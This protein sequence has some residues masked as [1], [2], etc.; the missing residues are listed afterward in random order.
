MG[1]R[2]I[3]ILGFVGVVLRVGPARADQTVNLTAVSMSV[4]VPDG[5]VLESSGGTDSFTR[6]ADGGYVGSFTIVA[7]ECASVIRSR[8][9]QGGTQIVEAVVTPLEGWSGFHFAGGGQT[10]GTY[11]RDVDI[12]ARY[13]AIVSGPPGVV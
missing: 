5:W 9:G 6:A 8:K 12:A 11:C 7:T 10:I 4:T 2:A 1:A 3:A 13:A